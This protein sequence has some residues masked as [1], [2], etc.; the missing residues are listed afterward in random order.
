MFQKSGQH[1]DAVPLPLTRRFAPTSP[2]GRGEESARAA[3]R[4]D[5]LRL[6]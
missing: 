1:R 4:N 5:N 3:P 6:C 2:P